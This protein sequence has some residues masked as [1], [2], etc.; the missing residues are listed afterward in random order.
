MLF[1]RKSWQ[2]YFL[3]NLTKIIN[4]TGKKT[5]NPF[6][7]PKEESGVCKQ[8]SVHQFLFLSFSAFFPFFFFFK[9]SFSFL[10]L[11]GSD[12]ARATQRR[13]GQ[14]L[15]MNNKRVGTK[16]ISDIFLL[17]TF[18]GAITYIASDSDRG[19]ASRWSFSTF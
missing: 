6:F 18:L 17:F 3:P 2:I 11:D 10:P 5:T 13:L 19:K 12:G 9:F 4:G 15:I 8:Y 14:E 7:I 1:S 16:E